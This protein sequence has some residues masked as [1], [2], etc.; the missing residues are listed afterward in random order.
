MKHGKIFFQT[1][2]TGD[3]T[4]KVIVD[5]GAQDVNGSLRKYSPVGA[6]YLGVDFVEG[7]GVDIVISDPYSLPF[8]DESIDVVVCSSVFEHSDFFWLLYLECLRILKPSGLLYINAPSNGMVHRYP[9]D[10][11]RFYPDSGLSLA[12]WAQH[13]GY[14]AELLESFIGEKSGLITGEGMWNDFVAVFLKNETYS[15]QFP[16]RIQDADG[17]LQN[18]YNSLVREESVSYCNVPDYDLIM[19]QQ[20]TIEQLV[21]SRDNQSQQLE[22][23]SRELSRIKG[24]HSWKMTQ[25]LRALRRSASLTYTKTHSAFHRKLR[26]FWHSSPLPAH[27]KELIRRCIRG[28]A[29]AYSTKPDIPTIKFDPTV[30][31][32]V[33]YQHNAPIDPLVKLIAFYLPQFHPFPENDEWWG[34]GFTEWYNVG[35]AHQNYE[36]HYQPHCPIHNGYYDLRVPSVMEEQAKLA[37]AYGI[38]GFSY[39]FYWFAG[40]ILMDTPLEMMLAN[41]KVDIPFCLTW[42]NENWTRRWDGQENDVLIAQDHSNE[43]SLAFIRHLVKFFNDPRYI[44]IDGKPVLVIY[45]ASIIPNMAL[46]AALWREEVKKH[47]IPDLYLICAQSFGIKGPEEF[48]F[49]ASVEFPPHTTKSTEISK[50]L[51]VTNPDFKGC[52]FSYEQ[53]VSN[54]IR[55]EEPDY[56]LFRTPMLSWDNTA[57][58]QHDSHSFHGFSLMRYKQWLSVACSNIHRTAKYNSDEKLVFINAWNEW[59]EGTHLEP[60]R[61]YGYGYLQAT[62]D[63][64]SSYDRQL[65]SKTDMTQFTQNN[66]YAVVLHI[67]YVELWPTIRQNLENLQHLG[68]D[69]FV[70]TTS[71]DILGLVRLE[72]PDAFVELHENRGRDIFPFIKILETISRFNYR[73]VCKLHT[74]MSLYRED[75]TQIRTQLVKT[76]IGSQTTVDKI[77]TRFSA[78]TSIGLIVPE[79]YLI[80]HNDQNMKYNRENVSYLSSR[81]EMNFR[82]DV[83]PA[84]SM[85]WFK[86]DAIRDLC[87]LKSS[88]FDV[89]HGLV[90]G[91]LPHAIERIFCLLAAKSGYTT[92]TC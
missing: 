84:G 54:S 36:G 53:V 55:E 42:A 5:V 86:P 16:C 77:V 57:R 70:T 17:S 68:F 81:L 66:S 34:K 9:V 4:G 47:G 90:D 6:T 69:L 50:Q 43:D 39:Y 12:K 63:V 74:K 30:E 51:N 40:K 52:I 58:K 61:K 83:F 76:L 8:E 67:H 22:S 72:F 62:Y 24:S 73:A 91:T 71:T 88:D 44:R 48:N 33:E 49:D 2:C 26:Q 79:K 32:Y 21:Q 38:H 56:K 80:A 3:F 20:S 59:A 29:S 78:N 19:K 25:P 75:G 65:V 1:Y 46:T 64:I 92:E 31:Q 11:W 28:A 27:H 60:D 45:R 15:A 13:N 87:R 10:S 41:P 35:R 89:E 23:T 18:G 85:F 14:K 7:S 82:Y 37:R